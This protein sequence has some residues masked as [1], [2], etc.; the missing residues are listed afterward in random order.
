MRPEALFL[1]V[2]SAFLVLDRGV[3][4]CITIGKDRSGRIR[5][6]DAADEFC[7]FLNACLGVQCPLE[8]VSTVGIEDD[9]PEDAQP[10]SDSLPAVCARMRSAACRD[11]HDR[12]EG[13]CAPNEYGR[14][15]WRG[16]A[17]GA[18][19]RP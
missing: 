3:A 9:S 8:S 15:I 17:K 11:A 1:A 18:C 10:F 13:S 5:Y 14:K 7:Q 2:L 12:A 6:G 16:E 4:R 19:A